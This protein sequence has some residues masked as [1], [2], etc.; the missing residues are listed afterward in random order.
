[1]TLFALGAAL[2]GGAP[3]AMAQDATVLWAQGEVQVKKADDPIAAT[4]VAGTALPQGAQIVTGQDG[5]CG[6]GLEGPLAGSA[7]EFKSGSTATL[8]DLGAQT[9]I[10]LT[11][12]GLFAKLSKLKKESSFEVSTPSAVATARGTAWEQSLDRIE[13]FEGTVQVKDISGQVESLSQGEAYDI[14][15]NGTYGARRAVT[16][17]SQEAF[18]TFAQRVTS[19]PYYNVVNAADILYVRGLID[20]K[21]NSCGS[22]SYPWQTEVQTGTIISSSEINELKT[23]LTKPPIQQTPVFTAT[24]LDPVGEIRS[25]EPVRAVTIQL[26]TD[27]ADNAAC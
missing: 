11:Q 24:Y 20:M 17:G 13:V 15:S 2:L 14:R 22:A 6:V 9:R 21:R 7:V 18:Q 8:D 23:A 5:S 27:A 25:G 10:N 3:A 12:G 16:A 26:L 19:S 1:M 4:A